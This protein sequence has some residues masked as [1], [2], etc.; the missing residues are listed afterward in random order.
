MAVPLGASDGGRQAELRATFPPSFVLAGSSKAELIGADS[1]RTF[2][3]DTNGYQCE[4][5]ALHD[6]AT[7]KTEPL[8]SLGEVV[9]DVIYALDLAEQVD[10]W[11]EAR[12]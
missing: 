8:I 12:P 6:A 1:T 7:G 11:L 9:D 10:R 5:D 3:F 4:W 2:E